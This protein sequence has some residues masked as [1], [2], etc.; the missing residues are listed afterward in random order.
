MRQRLWEAQKKLENAWPFPGKTSTFNLSIRDLIITCIVIFVSF[1]LYKKNKLWLF[2]PILALEPAILAFPFNVLCSLFIRTPRFFDALSLE[3]KL[4]ILQDRF[5][6]IQRET[7]SV[8][9]NKES[10]PFFADV[11]THQ[12][13]IAR[14][15]PWRVFPFFSYGNINYENCKKAPILSSLLFQIPSIRLAMLSMMEE[16]SEI[17]LHCGFF[18][19]VLRVHLCLWTDYEDKEEKRFIE[20]GGERYS[21]KE[22]ELVAFDD[23]YPH[24]VSNQIKGRRV[25]L[26]LDID[27]PYQTQISSLLG[28]ALLFL[29][30]ASPSVKSHAA[31]QEQIYKNTN[32]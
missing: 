9:S 30:K 18:K 31:L 15:Q 10:M 27:R 14:N 24:R 4:K 6:D 17:P 19:S 21:W 13:R 32:V 29:M 28:K 12:H 11:S 1:I 22:K 20:V 26:F 5:L 23:T 8:L 3:P 16:G 2:I 7:L 25:V